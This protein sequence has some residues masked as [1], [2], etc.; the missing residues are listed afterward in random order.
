MTDSGEPVWQ[1]EMTGPLSDIDFGD[2]RV[3]VTESS[4]VHCLQ[5]DSG[6]MVWSRELEGSSD[7]VVTTLSLIHI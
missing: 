3:Y 4:M 5:Y 2:D 7:Y 6:E 1:V